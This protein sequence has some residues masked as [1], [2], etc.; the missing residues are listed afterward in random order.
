ML[1]AP[2][3]I[4][5]W[6]CDRV[7]VEA[8]TGSVSIIA[9]HTRKRFRSFP[10]EADPFSVFAI[11]TGGHVSGI[12]E[13]RIVDLEEAEVLDRRILPIQ[14]PDPTA[15][16]RVHLRLRNMRFPHEGTYSFGLFV[17]NELIAE[18]HLRATTTR[19]KQ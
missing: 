9:S 17:D 16:V 8:E 14:F 12:M 10:A 19:G 11:V 5:L 4:G 6:I 2:Q 13:L 7:I 18:R 1:P 15:G 3:P